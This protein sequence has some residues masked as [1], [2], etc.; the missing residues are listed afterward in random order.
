MH[1]HQKQFCRFQNV[2]MTSSSQI[3]S[4]VIFTSNQ[5]LQQLSLQKFNALNDTKNYQL[6]FL[7]VSSSSTST[8][9]VIRPRL[10]IFLA[11]DIDY[12]RKIL[13]CF[14]YFDH[15]PTCCSDV[16]DR[17]CCQICDLYLTNI[18][19]LLQRVQGF[20]ALVRVVDPK[21]STRS[22]SIQFQFKARVHLICAILSL[23]E[24]CQITTHL[25]QIICSHN[26]SQ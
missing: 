17:L 22:C 24:P 23:L 12:S 13:G 9:N 20:L 18:V 3:H 4:F 5:R 10:K 11:N 15:N 25:A 7:C 6:Y 26:P 14:Y 8:T 2:Q 21:I 19:T 1:I 16:L